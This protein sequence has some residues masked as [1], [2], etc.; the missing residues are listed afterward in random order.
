MHNELSTDLKTAGEE[1]DHI[2]RVA[3]QHARS[4]ALYVLWQ[5]GVERLLFGCDGEDQVDS[6]EFRHLVD[7]PE[8]GDTVNVPKTRREREKKNLVHKHGRCADVVAKY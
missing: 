2:R 5:A 3:G 6:V 1:V 7:L 4:R 8:G